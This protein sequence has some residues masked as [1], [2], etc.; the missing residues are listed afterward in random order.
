MKSKKTLNTSYEE[1]AEF[2]YRIREAVHAD[3]CTIIKTK[4]T[5]CPDGCDCH[6]QLSVFTSIAWDL[7]KR[8]DCREGCDDCMKTVNILLDILVLGTTN[9]YHSMDTASERRLWLVLEELDR[10]RRELILR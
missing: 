2:A 1:R 5:H 6:P 10:Y 4:R 9:D 7:A 8:L 3:G